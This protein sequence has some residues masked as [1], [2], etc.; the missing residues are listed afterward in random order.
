MRYLW[1]TSF[2][3]VAIGALLIA[4]K[5]AG[6]FETIALVAGML[7]LWS[8]VVKVI[9]LRIWRSSLTLPGATERRSA[10]SKPVIGQPT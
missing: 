9:V 2:A 5:A 8:G 6:Y 1:L 7:L 3:M 10:P 4:G